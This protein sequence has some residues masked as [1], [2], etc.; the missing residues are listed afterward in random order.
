MGLVFVLLA[1]A[2]V[3][4]VLAGVAALFLG[5]AVAHLTRG[6]EH[7]RKRLIAFVCLFPFMCLAWAGAVF[8]FQAVVNETFFQRD[9]GLGDAWNCPLPNGYA[10]LMI[11][12][13]NEGWVYNPKT[14]PG[15]TV[16][17]QE[18]AIAGVR[19]LQVAGRY[20][21]GGSDSSFP[22]EEDR[23]DRIDSYFLLD[24]QTGRQTKFLDYEALRAKAQNLGIPTKLEPIGSIYSRYRF[25]WFDIFA[26]LLFVIPVLVGGLSMLRW[27]LRVRRA[28]REVS[29]NC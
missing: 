5:G 21:L 13:T 12:T 29:L 15:E 20:I 10:L 19:V 26:G 25:T 23:S 9:P 3:G 27:T 11:D 1:W 22:D 24:T 2:V 4:G 16:S 7:G 8:A 18:D 6:A 17:T 14:Q 28:R